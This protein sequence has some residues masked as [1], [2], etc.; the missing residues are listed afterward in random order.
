LASQLHTFLAELKRRKVFRVAVVYAAVAF[1]IWQAADFVL[2]AARVPDWAPTLV[3]VLTLAGFPIALVLAW[4]LELTPEGIRVTPPA[5]PPEGAAAGDQEPTGPPATEPA[6]P[7]AV[8][9]PVDDR[10]CV[11]VLPFANLSGDPEN[12]FFSD[13]VTEDIMAR[14]AGIR[15]LRVISRTTAMT[16]KGSQRNLPQIAAELGAQ[17]VVEGTVR[18]SAERVRVTAQLIAADRDE[19]LWA[20]TYDR[21]LED[22]FAVQSDVAENVAQALRAELTPGERERLQRKP[23]ENLEAYDLCLKGMRV[24][25][26]MYPEAIK[27]AERYF[28][29]AIALDPGYA[30]A[31]AGLAWTLGL[32]GWMGNV[33]TAELF[34]QVKAAAQD[35]IRLDP[36]V[37]EAYRALAAVAFW[38]EWDWAKGLR[39]LEKAVELNPDDSYAVGYRGWLLLVLGRVAE[40][41]A[42]LYEAV[43]LDPWSPMKRVWLASFYN[44]AGRHEE[45][46]AILDDLLRRDQRA[47]IALHFR[48]L[49]HMYAGNFT[50]AARDFDEG[51]ASIGRSILPVALKGAVHAFAGETQQARQILEELR[52]RAAHEYVDPYYLFTLSLPIDGFDAAFPYLEQMLEVRSVLVGFLRIAPRFKEL[53]SE[54]RFLN[55]LRTIWPDDF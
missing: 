14:L 46:V 18:R 23:T 40:A 22:V 53:R 16:Y 13:G 39:E 36:G 3:L 4:A 9:G 21:V 5:E 25:E 38:H 11:V 2:P 7:V 31:Y 54:P 28:R 51:I 48:G 37:G 19:H 41:E 6:K 10:P 35:A 32:N 45:G 27:E 1:V 20:E 49:C 29:E 50:A 15:G 33:A 8:Q 26:S 42:P 52:S 55:A 30:R 47:Y 34:P 12:E 17:A 43:R 44:Y 24:G